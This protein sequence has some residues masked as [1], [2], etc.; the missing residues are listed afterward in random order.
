MLHEW[1]LPGSKARAAFRPHRNVK[2]KDWRRRLCAASFDVQI[3]RPSGVLGGTFCVHAV[4]ASCARS[5]RAVSSSGQCARRASSR[6]G[7]FC[8][9]TSH[10]L[11]ARYRSFAIHYEDDDYDELRRHG[12]AKRLQTP[13][14]A[15]IR[16][17]Q[18]ES[19]LASHASRDG[20]FLAAKLNQLTRVGHVGIVFDIRVAR[21]RLTDA[22]GRCRSLR[23]FE[24]SPMSV[25]RVS[26]NPSGRCCCTEMFLAGY[27]HSPGFSNRPP[28]P[29]ISRSRYCRDSLRTMLPCTGSNPLAQETKP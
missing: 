3:D 14:L 27:D 10:A 11:H 8:D 21:D 5:A 2:K 9:R 26:R 22:H 13:D 7:S 23:H 16:K 12:N 25:R 4:A 19:G 1:L 20:R 29:L 6:N 15:M 24:G 17:E 28:C 18:M